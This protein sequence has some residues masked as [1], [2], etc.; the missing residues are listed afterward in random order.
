MK[1]A[2]QNPIKNGHLI[3]IDLVSAVCLIGVG[4][5][6]WYGRSEPNVQAVLDTPLTNK[7]R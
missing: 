2:V 5:Y 3:I 1:L 7:L 4:I 6:Y